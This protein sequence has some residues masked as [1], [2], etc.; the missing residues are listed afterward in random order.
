MDQLITVDGWELIF[1][2]AKTGR[3]PALYHALQVGG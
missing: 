3:L 1:G 2:P